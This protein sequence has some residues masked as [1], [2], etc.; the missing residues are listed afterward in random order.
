MALWVDKRLSVSSC[1][2]G[3]E[4]HGLLSDQLRNLCRDRDS[5]P[6]LLFYGPS[7]GGK[8]TRI[9][10]LLRTLFGVGVNKVQVAQKSFKIPNKSTPVE[11][12]V[13][14]SNYHIE[15]NPSDA[16][17]GDRHIIQQVLKEISETFQIDVNKSKQK[18][19]MSWKMVVINE[20]DRMTV[21]AQNAL[22]RLMESYMI[23][24]R[25]ILCC[26][27]LSRITAPIKSRCLIV[28][29]PHPPKSQLLAHLQCVAK[30]E[31]V[32]ADESHLKSI[33]EHSGGD[34]RLA[35][36]LM[37]AAHHNKGIVL[38]KNDWEG[39]LDAAIEKL[40][41]EQSLAN[42]SACKETIQTLLKHNIPPDF[43]LKRTLKFLLSLSFISS[44]CQIEIINLVAKID[45]NLGQ[46]SK[47]AIHLAALTDNLAL[48]LYKS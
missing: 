8:R 27:S 17:S 9:I 25:L 44:I 45:A 22:R 26:S 32:T 18:S 13:V 48:A 4:F 12:S 41:T 20:A 16:N 28:R 30:E 34:A 24:C 47:P 39:E 38:V 37:Q 2:G 5:F 35:V 29:V 10:A 31:K 23:S 14:H 42:I 6:H 40:A 3:L 36:L 15:L 7:G 21:D 33:C 46:G 11:I 19:K 43:I 1:L